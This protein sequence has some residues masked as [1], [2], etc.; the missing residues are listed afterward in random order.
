[1]AEGFE[2]CLW[3]LG[4]APQQHRTDNLSAAICRLARTG[5]RL[6]TERYQALMAHYGMQPSTNTPGEAHENGDV[7]QAHY[8]FKAAVDQA[9][10]IRGHRD[11]PDRAAYLRFL[12]D[13][14]RQRNGTR[15]TRFAEEREHL[16]P[17]PT[18]PLDPVQELRVTVSRF[19]TIRVLRNIYSV[20]S[21]LIGR[22]LTVRVRAETLELYLGA[23]RLD[24]LPRLRGQQR[25][26][27]D[28]RHLIES[29]VRKPGAFAHYRYRD[30]LFPSLIFRRAYD[31][32][33]QR[34]PQRA[35]QHYLRVLQLAAGTSEADVEAALSLLL[36]AGA[37]PTVDAVRDL[38]RGPEAITVPALACPQV[39]LVLYDQLLLLGRGYE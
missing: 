21:R 27:I 33:R 3:Q 12:S 25:H 30:E 23:T 15:Q 19:S 16:R 13:L 14:V 35:D 10:R 11:F 24:S 26:R 39:D 38:V 8:R 5:E 4:G 7:E 37:P 34:V 36:E 28:Y 17:L 20:P 2:A 22:T 18:T 1:M 32:L 9:L 6:F 31:A 29:L